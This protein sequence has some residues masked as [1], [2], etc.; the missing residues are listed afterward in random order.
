MSYYTMGF[1]FFSCLLEDTDKHIEVTDGHHVTAKQKGKVRIKMCDDNEDNFIATLHN[2]ILAPDLCDSLFSIITLINLGNT[3]LF[4]K[5]FCMVYFGA[6]EKNTVTLP[7][8]AQRKHAF[9]GEI[10]QISKTD[11]LPSRKKIALELL[12]Q[13]LGHISTISLLAVETSNLW[14]YIELRIYPYPFFAH[15]AIFLP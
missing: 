9:W 3:C 2:V 14:E 1:S 15:H 6:K 4:Q 7:H 8:S 11:K 12:H 10:K 13:R 5:V